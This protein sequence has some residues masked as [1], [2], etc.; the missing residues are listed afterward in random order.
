METTCGSSPSILQCHT[1]YLAGAD[2]KYRIAAKVL[3]NTKK[4][5]YY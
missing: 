5:Y 4:N 1:G 3:Q 2:Y